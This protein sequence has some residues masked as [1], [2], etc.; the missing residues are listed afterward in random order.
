L[1]VYW[2]GDYSIVSKKLITSY[3]PNSHK[4]NFEKEFLASYSEISNMFSKFYITPEYSSKYYDGNIIE[5]SIKVDIDS[6][7]VCPHYFFEL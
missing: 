2:V 7:I 4:L 6:K 1:P 3:N 5:D